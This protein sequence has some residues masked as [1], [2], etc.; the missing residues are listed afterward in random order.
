MKGLSLYVE[1]NTF[2]H[3]ADP[4]TKLLYVIVSVAAAYVAPS[5]WVGLAALAVGLALLAAARVLRR[6]WPVFAM[7][8]VVLST[9]FLIQGLF[10]PANVTPWLRVGPVVF[11]REGLLFALGITVRLLTLLASTVLLVLTTRP[12]DLIDALVR[13]GL[14]PKFGYVM[15][16]VLQIIP[17]M[18]GAASTILDAQRARGMETEG[19][20][21]TRL[22]AYIPLMGPL[23]TSSLIATQERAMALE[24]R[25]FNAE[26]R[27][28]FL[29]EET[30][31][32]L[33][34]AVRL[35]LVAV[36][37][38]VIVWRAVG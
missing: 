28:S 15:S 3:R 12:P 37:V 13:R 17:V 35:A 1:G 27:R 16:S 24:V 8:L 36:L 14:S 23:V 34:G 2:V 9:V 29:R 30:V 4:I 19:R 18:A 7:S 11:Y 21:S 31:P 38:L 25:A 26:G 33:T 6:S 20:F 22:K 10:N 32:P 5:L